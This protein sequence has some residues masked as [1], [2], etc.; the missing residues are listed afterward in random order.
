[1]EFTEAKERLKHSWAAD[2]DDFARVKSALKTK[3]AEHH[4]QSGRL[5]QQIKVSSALLI[6]MAHAQASCGTDGP[7]NA[8]VARCQA[9]NVLNLACHNFVCTRGTAR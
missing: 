9:Q 5:S 3:N 8:F 2:R 1:M 7:Q 6:V 4:A